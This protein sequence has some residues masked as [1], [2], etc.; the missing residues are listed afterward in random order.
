MTWRA[1]ASAAALWILLTQGAVAQVTVLTR[2]DAAAGEHAENLAVAADGAVFVSLLTGGLYIRAANGDERR[3]RVGGPHASL[4]G[5]AI[6]RDGHVLV[7][8]DRRGGEGPKGVWRLDPT[9][10]RAEQV[11]SLPS[12]A[13]VNGVAV[14]GEGRIYVADSHGV[15][16]RADRPGAIPARWL[17]GRAVVPRA[18][19]A[20]VDGRPG[21]TLAVGPN[22]LKVRGDE[23]YVS[24]S[25]QAR[26][27]AVPIG[28]RPGRVRTVAR[29]VY[30]DDFAFDGE[31][32]LVVASDR[33]QVLATRIERL[34][35]HGRPTALTTDSDQ[36]QQPSAIA[37]DPRVDGFLITTLGLFGAQQ[38]PA[39]F[40]L[41][42]KP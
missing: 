12:T 22:G 2:F 40:S 24:L 26:I 25:G 39:L 33:R 17:T 4:T 28:D 37:L 21:P 5:L 34:D 20:M 36:L 32:R 41:P 19:R 13:M 9:T 10:G 30:V 14:D 1:F 42:A 11:V 18:R 15:V 35:E 3:L 29:S 23:L 6:D 7:G 31:G 38:R 8:V 27:I 16:W